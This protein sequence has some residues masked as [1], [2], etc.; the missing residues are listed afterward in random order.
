MR[1]AEILEHWRGIKPNQSISIGAVAYKH[2]GSTYDEDGIRITGSQKF[3]DS[4]L[5]R[6]SELLDYEGDG[7]RLQLVYKRSVDKDTGVELDSYNCYI[8]VHERGRE[9]QICNAFVRGIKERNLSKY[10]A[11]VMA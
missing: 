1:K 10:Q 11:A 4:V 6:L 9:A 2:K 5:S 3:I 8:Q 7:T